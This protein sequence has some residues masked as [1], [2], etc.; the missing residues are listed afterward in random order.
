MRTSKVL[1]LAAALL[2]GGCAAIDPHNLLSRSVRDSNADFHVNV[3]GNWGRN[4]AFD[5]V[6]DTINE[7]Y[8]DPKFNGI[9]W[10]AA[11]AR[12]RPLAVGARNDEEFW[13]VLNGRA[14]ELP[15]SHTR[16]EPPNFVALRRRQ[17]A[18]SLGIDIDRVED[19]IVVTFVA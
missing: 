8:V 9:D 13:N 16:V 2:V 14:G 7:N 1:M 11:A 10:K 3:L 18:V 6:W 19:R 12:S 4:A 17:E 5:F 15:D